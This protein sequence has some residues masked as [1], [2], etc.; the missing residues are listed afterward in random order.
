VG[1]TFAGDAT[2]APSMPQDSPAHNANDAPKYASDLSRN[3]MLAM[4]SLAARMFD[5]ALLRHSFASWHRSA[6]IEVLVELESRL[7][8]QDRICDFLSS[9]ACAGADP[10]ETQAT[11]AK[12]VSLQA[13]SDRWKASAAESAAVVTALR[14]ELGDLRKE[15]K[16]VSLQAESE[17]WQ[18]SA[19]ESAAVV[20]ALRAELGDL[21]KGA[22]DAHFAAQTNSDFAAL[23]AEL[24]ESQAECERLRAVTTTASAAS[25]VS[26]DLPK[27]D[28]ASQ[29]IAKIEKNRV[30]CERLQATVA[31]VESL[32]AE[33]ERWKASA[34]E[35]VAVV[36]AL[37]AEL[38]G[39]RNRRFSAGAADARFAAKTNSDLPAL[40]EELAERQAE[41]EHLRA[42]VTRILPNYMR[43]YM[44]NLPTHLRSRYTIP[45]KN[46]CDTF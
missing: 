28:H 22:K 38:G 42:V 46:H 35:S 8:G 18:A 40:H 7:E 14:A 15:S 3:P 20:T 19:A 5:A 1:I 11:E 4:D 41:G 34:A 12:A 21:R 6:M 37:R 45:R 29:K 13:E 32:Q 10:W 33:S 16:A 36:T 43:C 30:L 26:L 17:R 23:N 24:A 2:K 9:A 39:L 27:D 31:K 44:R 25:K